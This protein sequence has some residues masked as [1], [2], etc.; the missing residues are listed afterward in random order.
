MPSVIYSLDME[1]D[2][3]YGLIPFVE[4]LDTYDA[5]MTLTFLVGEGHSGIKVLR[6][7]EL[8]AL[9]QK[10]GYLKE[11]IKIDFIQGYGS[12]KVFELDGVEL[13]ESKE[14]VSLRLAAEGFGDGSTELEHIHALEK[15]NTVFSGSPETFVIGTKPPREFIDLC[16]QKEG[17]GLLKRAIYSGTF[18]FNIRTLMNEAEERVQAPFD[19][20]LS[21]AEKAKD[22]GKDAHFGALMAE[23]E[24][25]KT[26]DETLFA[27]L[28]TEVERAKGQD[29]KTASALVDKAKKA[30]V[31]KAVEAV[32][33]AIFSFMST[34]REVY[35]FESYFASG[36]TNSY[37]ED[38]FPG[39][40]EHLEKTPFG[41][42]LALLIKNW[43][44]QQ[45]GS[46]PEKVARFAKDHASK[47]IIIETYSS[48]WT[49]ER[50]DLILS[51]LS[52]DHIQD[53]DKQAKEK[54]GIHRKLKK[55]CNMTSGGQQVIV[56]DVVGMM[57]FL[58]AEAIKT[59]AL[60]LQVGFNHRGYTVLSTE[61]GA[62]AGVKVFLIAPESLTP[63]Q[64]SDYQSFMAE[65]MAIEEKIKDADKQQQNIP[66]T[67]LASLE[68]IKRNLKELP[69]VALMQKEVFDIAAV[70]L[71]R[72]CEKILCLLTEAQA[73]LA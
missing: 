20:I 4:M 5:E 41:R 26:Q 47:R 21:K 23:L 6:M 65:K 12:S 70:S 3:I 72:S 68:G 16:A 69:P 67:L 2:D 34:W 37:N 29:M 50:Q 31:G 9:L 42:S 52:F 7:Q 46:D 15:L 49:K 56:A 48:N 27:A 18:S 44:A 14:A 61:D 71:A 53:L 54:D 40:F 62:S 51:H 19:L 73:C 38:K 33:R 59:Q 58:G 11:N 25:A 66:V 24:R 39:I 28:I 64:F 8:V 57:A 35:Y 36:S 43:N 55:W 1:P 63:K 32:K 30:E 13:F 45:L 10:Q 17:P 22:Q 60:P